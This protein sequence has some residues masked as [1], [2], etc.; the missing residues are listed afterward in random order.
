MK[1][2]VEENPKK[3]AKTSPKSSSKTTKLEDEITNAVKLI[4]QTNSGS[5]LKEC[6]EKL[7]SLGWRATNPLHRKALGIFCD[8]E[9]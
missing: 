6:K 4:V 8:R 1:P 2:V 3:K 9:Q 5:S 7:K